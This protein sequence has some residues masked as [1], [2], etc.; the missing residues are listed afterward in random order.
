MEPPCQGGPNLGP[1]LNEMLSR[2]DRFTSS[3][4]LDSGDIRD[5]EEGIGFRDFKEARNG[6][7]AALGRL[8][9][10]H[11]L[12]LLDHCQRVLGPGLL[13]NAR[14][15]D[16]LQ[17]AYLQ[18]LIRIKACR[19]ESERQFMAWVFQIIGNHARELARFYSA[20]KRRSVADPHSSQTP[21][22]AGDLRTPSREFSGREELSAVLS[23][24]ETLSPSHREVLTLCVHEGLTP[25]QA[26]Q[27]L[28]KS[29]EATR[30]LLFRARAA[31]ALACKKLRPG[32]PES[33]FELLPTKD[34]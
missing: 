2:M 4:F 34:S 12:R 16:L 1:G 30:I 32:S 28:G 6:D 31:L 26:A 29:A 23:A 7:A 13:S 25:I 5:D 8:L 22:D 24:I 9:S 15:S 20:R 33:P 19:A 27:R 17:S 3:E 14:P 21:A 11:Q 10:R 18:I